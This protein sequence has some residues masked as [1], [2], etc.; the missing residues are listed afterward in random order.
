MRN[1]AFEGIDTVFQN[2]LNKDINM[3]NKDPFLF[4]FLKIKL[5]TFIKLVTKTPIA[6][7]CETTSQSRTKGLTLI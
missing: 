3:I 1:I 5:T 6:N 4:I 7:Y 2:Q